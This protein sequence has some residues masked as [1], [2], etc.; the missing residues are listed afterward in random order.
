MHTV[1]STVAYTYP[2]FPTPS[3]TL[4]SLHSVN[5]NAGGRVRTGVDHR[6]NGARVC[7]RFGCSARLPTHVPGDMCG[8]CAGAGFVRPPPAGV[9]RRI[10]RRATECTFP[11]PRESLDL[12]GTLSLQK[13]AH[14][15][16]MTMESMNVGDELEV[17][18]VYP[19][20]VPVATQCVS[21]ISESTSE[22]SKPIQ[23]EDVELEL[24]YPEDAAETAWALSSK[25]QI[26]VSPPTTLRQCFRNGL[27]T[28]PALQNLT[29]LTNKNPIRRCRMPG[30]NE[31]LP[32]HS[33]MEYCVK[34]SIV[35]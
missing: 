6:G 35:R 4:S 21:T 32:A 5:A 18:L 12:V 9:Q 8:V 11:R 29:T 2:H 17:D 23:D 3:Q 16:A 20:D 15:T 24:V 13:A 30:C 7:I 27:Q 1:A 28:V 25:P 19:D 33:R 14:G 34:C 22:E 31:T 26:K 10:P